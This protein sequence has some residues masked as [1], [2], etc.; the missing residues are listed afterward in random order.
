MS[1]T[2]G[3]FFKEYFWKWLIA[4]SGLFIIFL[5]VGI[6]AFLIYKGLDTFTLFGHTLGEFFFS[7]NFDPAHGLETEQGT[8]GAASFIVGSLLTC[9]LALAIATPFSLSAAIFMTEISPKLGNRFLQPAVEIFVGIPSVV[10]GWTAMIILSPI[11]ANMFSLNHGRTILT[12]ALVLSV[13][14]FPTITSVSSDAIRGVP[15][16]HRDA[17]YG[18][19]A[20]RWQMIYQVIVP[21]ATPGVMTGIVLGLARAFGEALAVAMV[22][23]R[24]TAFP[25]GLLS[26]GHTLTTVITTYMGEAVEGEELKAALWS[27]ALLLY[28][29]SLLFIFIVH[30]IAKKG[31][32][33]ANGKD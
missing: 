11:I 12:A 30:L 29:I 18:L 31:E 15:K 3:M 17:A 23:G 8:V 26:S 32:K 25:S 5:T 28:L 22:I 19:G 9:G 2:K 27:L 1:K 13:M 6:G 14:I 7:T 33:T 20:T 21:S 24:S 10:Y 4:G 16:M